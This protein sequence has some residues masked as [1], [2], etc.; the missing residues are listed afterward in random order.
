[1]SEIAWLSERDSDDPGRLRSAEDR[2]DHE[3]HAVCDKCG[4][5]ARY[6]L[7]LQGVGIACSK[8]CMDVLEAQYAEAVQGRRD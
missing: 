1:M 7:T 3:F 4:R 2:G 8:A 6:P 5:D